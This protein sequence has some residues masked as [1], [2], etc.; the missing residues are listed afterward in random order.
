LSFGL[1]YIIREK[2]MLRTG[3]TLE[4]LRSSF[5]IGFRPGRFRIDYAADVHP[6]LGISHE[7]SVTLNI[8]YK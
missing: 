7:F 5:G 1:E 2:I 3:V 6:L 8:K 4:T